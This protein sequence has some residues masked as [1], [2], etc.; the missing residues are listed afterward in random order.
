[1]NTT[2]EKFQTLLNERQQRF[3]NEGYD[4]SFAVV[5]N[6]DEG[7]ELFAEMHLAN[8]DVPTQS[9][10]HCALLGLQWP[11]PQSEFEKKWLA[12]FGPSVAGVGSGGTPPSYPSEEQTRRSTAK[13]AGGS[14]QGDAKLKDEG[15]RGF[16][17]EV[18]R[19]MAL[20]KSYS[21]SWAI[22]SSTS[23]GKEFYAQWS[24]GAAEVRRSA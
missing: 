15:R 7:R 6:S 22:A 14:F 2:S 1:M 17:D 20:G 11:A 5:A 10:R 19:E 12:K 8:S 24:R 16:L 18:A 23:P 21:E 13:A 4:A 9:P 3:P